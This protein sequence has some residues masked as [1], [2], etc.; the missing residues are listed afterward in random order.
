MITEVFQGSSYPETLAR[1]W[2]ALLGRNHF[3]NPFLSPTWHEIWLKHFGQ[4]L[5]VQVIIF[6]AL[7]GTL[8]A[9]GAFAN[10]T[11]EGGQKGLSLLGSAE[12]SDYRDLVITPGK[13]EEAFSA[14]A[15]IF[16]E[17]PWEYLELNGISE[18]SPTVQFFPSIAQS[19][20]FGVSQEIEEVGLYLDLPETWDFFLAGLKTKDRHELRR[21]MRRM[22]REAFI[23]ELGVEDAP[24]L[25]EKME[26]FFDL[27]R[28]SRK[29]KAQ[30]MTPEMK[31]FFRELSTRF[32][33]KGW[34]NLFLLKV[35]EKEI[36]A[37]FSFDFEGVEYLYN[38]G[39]DPQFAPL[40]PGIVLAALCIRRAIEK[41][42]VGFNFLRG[43][44][45]Y[46]YHLGGREEKI[47]RIMV[48]KR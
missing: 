7:E 28:K 37:L 45:D 13:E 40:S 31:A 19:L 39:Y 30:F 20:G 33:E 46:K 22:E 38:S 24:S 23:L 17:G 21:K 3:R 4:S 14:L 34:L 5:D 26:V 41:G 32:Q 15:R 10:S 27:H 6:R 48:K 11:G 16:A 35:E 42:M 12:V 47:Y 44:E 18:F 29:D 25:Q 43:R 2:E 36:A 1:E 9:L 8:L